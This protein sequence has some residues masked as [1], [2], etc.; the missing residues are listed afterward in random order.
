MF[1]IYFGAAKATTARS[2]RTDRLSLGA[3]Y[4][5]VF[6]SLPKPSLLFPKTVERSTR[7]VYRSH[8]VAALKCEADARRQYTNFVPGELGVRA[9][10]YLKVFELKGPCNT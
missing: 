2:W 4:C 3:R 6:L 9:P 8:D 7:S 5:P 10:V 1:T